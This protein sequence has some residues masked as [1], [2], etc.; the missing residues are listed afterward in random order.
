V[1]LL[2]SSKFGLIRLNGEK[3][4]NMWGNF[5]IFD[6]SNVRLWLLQDF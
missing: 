2:N 1:S 6:C 3:V 5:F 4:G